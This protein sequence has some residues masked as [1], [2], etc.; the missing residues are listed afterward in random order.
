MKCDCIDRVEKELAEKFANDLGVEHVTA[1]CQSS[2]FS[3][4][5]NTM[6]V[7]FKSDFR[8]RAEAKGFRRGKSVPVIAAFCPFCGTP[9]GV[10]KES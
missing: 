5:G 2:G 10:Q 6:I 3:I 1:E 7:V 4:Q 9:T 8:I